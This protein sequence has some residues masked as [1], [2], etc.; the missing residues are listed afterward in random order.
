MIAVAAVVAVA[1]VEMSRSVIEW[2]WPIY[3]SACGRIGDMVD[4][5]PTLSRLLSCP[6]QGYWRRGRSVDV[7][8]G[9]FVLDEGRHRAVETWAMGDDPSGALPCRSPVKNRSCLFESLWHHNAYI[10]TYG[11]YL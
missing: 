9:A 7:L 10:P 4:E 2:W 3:G 8:N 5:V 1:E 11:S 6:D